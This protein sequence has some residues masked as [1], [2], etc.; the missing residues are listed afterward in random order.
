MPAIRA[1]PVVVFLLALV[2]PWR[3]LAQDPSIDDIVVRVD[4]RDS[5]V[6][7]DVEVPMAV[8]PEEAWSTLT[9]YDHMSEFIPN[10]TESRVLGRSGNNLRI[11]QKGRAQK[12]PLSFSFENVRDVV[13]VP[14]HEIRTRLVSGSLRDAESLTRIERTETGSRLINHGEYT[15]SPLLPVQV[16]RQM[17][18]SETREQF[19]LMRA[20]VMRRHA[21]VAVTP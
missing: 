13:L 12:G 16:A 14:P 18:A 5:T 8:S 11:V 6:I 3:A 10:L 9:D 17:I 2:A 7:I 1:I 15:V 21:R 4:T 19:G 20:E